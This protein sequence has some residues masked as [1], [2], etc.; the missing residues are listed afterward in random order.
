MDIKNFQTGKVNCSL[1][2]FLN[3]YYGLKS[4][5]SEGF[6]GDWEYTSCPLWEAFHKE[7]Y[8]PII[9]IHTLHL[10]PF[11]R[12]RGILQ[13]FYFWQ[14]FYTF[15]H[16][17]NSFAFSGWK[18]S[19]HFYALTNFIFLFLFVNFQIVPQERNSGPRLF[20]L[21]AF[22]CDVETPPFP[23]SWWWYIALTQ[24]CFA[25]FF[26]NPVSSFSVSFLIFPI[27]LFPMRDVD[28]WY[29]DPLYL[30]LT[31]WWFPF[32]FCLN[33]ISSPASYTRVPTPS[34]LWLGLFLHLKLWQ[35]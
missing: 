2:Y 12:M 6:C 31:F 11:L 7:A 35:S 24:Q 9:Y 29:E 27:P 23:F 5:T 17:A 21:Y 25:Q 22:F 10:G 33:S 3:G 13:R 34:P 8:K 18:H 1:F 30:P 4:M 14:Y 20:D 32:I 26:S 15:I 19:T 28:I 16:L